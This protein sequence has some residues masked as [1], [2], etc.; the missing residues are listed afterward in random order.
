MKLLK[1]GKTAEQ[2]DIGTIKK[3]IF[4][5]EITLHGL[6]A[7]KLSMKCNIYTNPT[8]RHGERACSWLSRK[9]KI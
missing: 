3:R 8:L 2:E 4:S 1:L 9:H 7:M 5:P 6:T